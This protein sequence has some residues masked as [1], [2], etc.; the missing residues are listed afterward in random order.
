MNYGKLIL[1]SVVFSLLF[2]LV[3]YLIKTW[4]V[5]A[6]FSSILGSGT[7]KDLFDQVDESSVDPLASAQEGCPTFDDIVN[8]KNNGCFSS[9]LPETFWTDANLGDLTVTS[10]ISTC[11]SQDT[12]LTEDLCSLAVLELRNQ[13]DLIHG[14]DTLS[15]LDEDPATALMKGCYLDSELWSWM[16]EYYTQTDNGYVLGQFGYT[17]A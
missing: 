5:K 2:I 12:V 9:I 17:E 4:R 6:R 3:Q 15:S 1:Q 8:A 11:F 14:Y 7:L 10:A 16:N 13:I